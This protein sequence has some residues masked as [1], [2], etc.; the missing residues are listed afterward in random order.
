MHTDFVWFLLTMYYRWIDDVT[1]K[2]VFL[3]CY[4]IMVTDDIKI[5]FFIRRMA[6]WNTPGLAAELAVKTPL[7][8]YH[9]HWRDYFTFLVTKYIFILFPKQSDFDSPK[10]IL[11]LVG[12]KKWV[13]DFALHDIKKSLIFS[14]W[15]SDLFVYHKFFK[16]SLNTMIV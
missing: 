12:V 13:G 9:Y 15:L 6:T 1:I 8:W 11:S 7:F 5:F 14:H 2:N 10:P 16:K 3:L 4:S